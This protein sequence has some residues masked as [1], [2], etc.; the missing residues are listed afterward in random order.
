MLDSDGRP[1]E[2]ANPW[3]CQL[4]SDICECQPFDD[5]YELVSWVDGRPLQLFL[6]PELRAFFLG[7]NFTIMRHAALGVAIPPAGTYGCAEVEAN[8]GL[9]PFYL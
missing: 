7:R 1:T 9:P 8:T 3:I 5:L 2:D 4:L 6:D